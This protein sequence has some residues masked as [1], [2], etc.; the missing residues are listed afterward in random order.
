MSRPRGGKPPFFF[1]L[2]S[3][4]TFLKAFRGCLALGL[5]TTSSSNLETKRQHQHEP[6]HHQPLPLAHRQI[7]ALL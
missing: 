7:L 6:R 4:G 5:G 1:H 2:S 3:A